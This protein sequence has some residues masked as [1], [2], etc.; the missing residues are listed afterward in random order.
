[1]IKREIE[2]LIKIHF[3]DSQYDISEQL[4]E[5]NELISHNSYVVLVF[6]SISFLICLLYDLFKKYREI[7]IV[8]LMGYKQINIFYNYFK[9][10]LFVFYCLT[11]FNVII[12]YS[13]CF[14]E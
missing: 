10:K 6:F 13:L 9:R 4:S 5:H 7:A 12:L 14:Q 11:F 1:M 3:D 2:E 8:N